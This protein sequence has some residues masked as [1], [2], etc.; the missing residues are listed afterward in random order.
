M[1]KDITRLKPRELECVRQLA[2]DKDYP[3]GAAALCITRQTFKNY[4]QSA[5]RS[6]GYRTRDGLVAA[7][8]QRYGLD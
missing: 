8:V 3:E 7:Y 1:N 6:S 2:H 5:K 4:I